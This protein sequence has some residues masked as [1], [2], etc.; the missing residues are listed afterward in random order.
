MEIYNKI[1]NHELPNS[2]L[3]RNAVIQYLN[4]GK[5]DDSTEN[6]DTS[7]DTY[8][9]VYNTL[10]T[11]EMTPLK[12]EVKHLNDNISRLE[13]NVCDLKDDK[14]FLQDQL[15]AQ[16]VIAAAKTLLLT[17]IKIKLLGQ[18]RE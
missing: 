13:Q 14:L 3:I 9:K 1:D 16:S 2:Q 18:N 7:E 12:Q 11:T 17:C 8:N 6:I 15:R 10:Y 4:D 5:Q